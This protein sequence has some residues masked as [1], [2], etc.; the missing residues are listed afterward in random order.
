MIAPAAFEDLTFPEQKLIPWSSYES[1][2]WMRAYTNY[3]NQLV[4]P[5]ASYGTPI[6]LS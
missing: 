4:I 6:V 2:Q 3:F 1:D 5:S